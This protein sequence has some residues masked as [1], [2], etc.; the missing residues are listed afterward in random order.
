LVVLTLLDTLLT[1]L[2]HL[3]VPDIVRLSMASKI[4][5]VHP[6]IVVTHKFLSHAIDI[7][8]SCLV[9]VQGAENRD[10][11]QQDRLASRSS[12]T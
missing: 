4:L 5:F 3:H 8:V 12:A 2:S 11:A 9:G 10:R 1:V 7:H 6:S